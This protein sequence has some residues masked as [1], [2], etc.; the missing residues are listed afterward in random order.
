MTRWLRGFGSLVLSDLRQFYRVRLIVL[1]SSLMPV[2]MTL[3]FGLGGG[4]RATGEV[5]SFAFIFPGILA[6]AT[7]FSAMFSGGYGIILDRQQSVIRD[8]MLSPVSYSA[9]VMARLVGVVLKSTPPLACALVCALPFLADW[10]PPHPFVALGTYALSALLFAAVGMWIGSFSNVMTFPGLANFVLMPFMFFCGV[11]FP[12]DNLGGLR[13]LVE[14]LP[15]TSTVELYRYALTGAELPAVAGKVALL[16]LYAAAT[17]A[18]WT[19]IFK[20]RVVNEP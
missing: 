15:F 13:P 14:A 16:A 10:T 5:P 19:W 7:M 8:L 2:A 6:L 17:V 20:K 1:S 11:F 9:Y 4:D 3:S 18:L 12:V